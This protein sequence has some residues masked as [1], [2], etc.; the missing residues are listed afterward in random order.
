MKK[1]Q[2]ELTFLEHLEQLR[3][4][5]LRAILAIMVVAI[6]VFIMRN[7][8][9]NQVIL[10]PKNP[11]FFTN[12][13]LCRLGEKLNSSSICINSEPIEIIN[14]RMSGQLTIHIVISIVLGLIF[15]FPYV[16]WEFWNFIKPALYDNEIKH[17]RGAVFFSSLLFIIGVVFGYFIIVPLSIHFLGTYHVSDQ[18]V[19][20]INLKSYI[21]TIA[22]VV[23][24][25]GAIFELPILIYFLS[26]AGLV[27][28]S[29]LKK[30]RKHSIVL[31]L[32][33]AATITPPDIFSL[34]MVTLPLVILYEV[35]ISISKRI[36]KKK[37]KEELAG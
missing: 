1:K 17:S 20:Q 27:T 6:V 25:A 34:I 37:E 14:I 22:S 4:H 21:G 12:N 11:E 2:Q 3:W 9:F 10:A 30:Y 33:L 26:K 35:G 18:V 5:I 24:A 36:E 7:F 32:M 19:N 15:A 13:L 29:F 16:F 31:I 28:P 8:I 23:L